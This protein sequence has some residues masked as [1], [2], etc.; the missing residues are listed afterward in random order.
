MP[1]TTGE[2]RRKNDPIRGWREQPTERN[3]RVGQGRPSGSARIYTPSPDS[4]TR[5][6]GAH[7]KR[8][9]PGATDTKSPAGGIAPH[10]STR[11]SPPVLPCCCNTARESA[12]FAMALAWEHSTPFF[13]Y[14]DFA[15]LGIPL[16]ILRVVPRSERVHKHVLPWDSAEAD[17]EGSKAIMKQVVRSHIRNDVIL[18]RSFR[19]IPPPIAGGGLVYDR[20]M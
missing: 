15:S 2:A 6:G 9:C 16:Y 13:K 7:A 20:G 19:C 3:G 1:G 10:V 11:R 8:T 17:Y 12:P 18:Y 4:Q 5:S 14:T